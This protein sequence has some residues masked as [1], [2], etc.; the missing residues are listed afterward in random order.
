MK[1]ALHAVRFTNQVKQLKTTLD[2]KRNAHQAHVRLYLDTD[3]NAIIVE[4]ERNPKYPKL[5]IPVVGNVEFYEPVEDEAPP[6]TAP[7]K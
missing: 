7:K 4:D 2:P 3:R 5:H 6:A 1:I